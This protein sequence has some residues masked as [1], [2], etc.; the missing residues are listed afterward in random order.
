MHRVHRCSQV[1]TQLFHL[2]VE[3][4]PARVENYRLKLLHIASTLQLEHQGHP[5]A[6]TSAGALPVQE[7]SSTL[8]PLQSSLREVLQHLVGDRTEAL[9]TGART[10]Y[11]WT[12]GKWAE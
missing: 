3:G 9:R 12:V 6:G 5:N 4:S 1:F 2:S 11:G 10:V 8:S 7:G